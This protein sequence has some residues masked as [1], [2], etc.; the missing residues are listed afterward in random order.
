[1]VTQFPNGPHIRYLVTAASWLNVAEIVWF[2]VTLV[3]V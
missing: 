3:N 2:A 1:M